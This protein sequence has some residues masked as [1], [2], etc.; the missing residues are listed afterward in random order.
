MLFFRYRFENRY[1]KPSWFSRFWKQNYWR[2]MRENKRNVGGRKDKKWTE[3]ARKWQVRDHRKSKNV[4]FIVCYITLKRMLSHWHVFDLASCQTCL[5]RHKK[6]LDVYSSCGHAKYN[7][8]M[9]YRVIIPIQTELYLQ[10][11]DGTMSP[12]PQNVTSLPVGFTQ[13]G[14]HMLWSSKCI[15]LRHDHNGP[16]NAFPI[17]PSDSMFNFMKPLAYHIK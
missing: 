12:P 4:L 17:H 14:Y 8:E 3:T 15:E 9:N 1:P 2:D 16:G 10:R 13:H 6:T 5:R 11:T 7:S